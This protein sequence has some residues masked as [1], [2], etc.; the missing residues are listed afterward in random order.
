VEFSILITDLHGWGYDG[1][2]SPAV[3]GGR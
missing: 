2:R 1:S 3:S